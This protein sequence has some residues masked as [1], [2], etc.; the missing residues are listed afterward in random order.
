MCE[1]C[2]YGTE[3]GDCFLFWLLLSFI[4]WGRISCRT[5]DHRF[6]WSNWMLAVWILG[7]ILLSIYSEVTSTDVQHWY[8]PSNQTLIL[9]HWAFCPVT[10]DC[11]LASRSQ[12]AS[13]RLECKAPSF[14][15][16][17]ASESRNQLQFIH[18]YRGDIWTFREMCSGTQEKSWHSTNHR[19]I[20]FH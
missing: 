12:N 9:T 1:K 15:S 17:Y 3:V 14:L 6:I 7:L 18:M 4:Y 13:R 11:W 16:E 10:Y 8:V 5:G 19:G 2:V 20:S